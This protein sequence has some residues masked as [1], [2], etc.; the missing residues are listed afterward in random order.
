[1]NEQLSSFLNN[2]VKEYNRL[3]FIDKDPVC[4]P[5]LFK[6]KQDIEIAG[7]FA[8]IFAWGIR[9]TI[10]NK[11]KELLQRMDDAPY[12]FCINHGDEDLKKLLGFKHRTFNDTDLLYFISFFKHHYTKHESLEDAFLI[13]KKKKTD[14]VEEML[15]GFYEYFFSLPFVPQRT[16][17]HIAS[18]AKNSTC[19]RLC[20]Y[21][22]WMVRKDNCGVD[23]G[24]WHDIKMQDLMIPLDLHVGRVARNFGLITRPATDWQTVVELTNEMKT[25]DPKDPS[26][27]DYALF[28]LGISEKF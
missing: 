12:D 18:P 19:K 20:M 13:G 21:L 26:K 1:M 22:R 15:N 9:K 27:Y 4:I 23:L 5:H 3:S 6:K 17:K 8:A 11:S 10:I 7:F 25:L 2:K 28:A 16:M 24:I 14:G